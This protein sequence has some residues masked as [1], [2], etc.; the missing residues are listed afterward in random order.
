MYVEGGM[1]YD[2]VFELLYGDFFFNLCVFLGDILYKVC[3]F[4]DDIFL[5]MSD[6]NSLF[7]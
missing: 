1:D 7:K 2:L 4:N 3:Y 5:R 6:E